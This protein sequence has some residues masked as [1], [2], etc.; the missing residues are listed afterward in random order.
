MAFIRNCVITAV[1]V[2][3]IAGNAK[4]Q[5]IYYPALSSSLLKETAADMAML[6]QKAIP[7]S[8]FTTASYN[9]MP[10][11]G[12]VFIY[13][14]TI[15][16]NQTCKAI[17]NGTDLLRFS[18]MQDN[19]LH[20]GV[21]QYLNQLGYRFYQPG[22]IWEK[23]PTLATAFKKTDTTYT[24]SYKYK[25]WFISGG[26]NRWIMDNTAA[27]SWDRYAGENGHNWAKFQRRNGMVGAANFRGHRG[28]IMTGNYITTLQN[29]PCY[30]ANYNGS[31]QVNNQSVP[32]IFNAAAI[33]LWATTIEQKYTQ[34]KNTISS[35]QTLYVNQYRNSDYSHIGLEVPDGS[36]WGNSKLN[37]ACGAANY[38]EEA[39]QQFMLA[40]ATAERILSKH[41]SVRFQVYAYSGH[42]DVPA[43]NITIN[44]NIDVQM[45]PTVY[46]LETSTGGLRNRWYNRHQ[47]VSEYHYLNLSGW[48]GETPAFNWS[49]LKQT[50]Q[51]AKEK[52]SQGL[53]WEASPAKFGSLPYLLAANN[54]LLRGT[55]VDNTLQEFCTNMFDAAS[56]TILQ[57]LQM[58]GSENASPDRYKVQLYLKLLNT[59]VQQ[60]Q[61]A[62]AVVKQRLREL[63]AYLHYMVL[64]YKL[65]SDDRSKTSNEVRDAAICMYLAKTNRLQLVNSYYILLIT[66]AKY[67]TS[68]SFYAQYNP[69]NGTAYSGGNIPLIS[70]AEIDTDFAQDL[71]QYNNM[72]NEFALLDAAEI[73]NNFATS[74]M[75][76]LPLINTTIGYT[77]GKDY[78]GKATFDIIAPAAGSFTIKYAPKFNTPGKG[79]I[80]FLVEATDKALVIVKD[81]TINVANGADV[82]TVNLPAAG[83]YQFSVTSK[84]QSSVDMSIT[85]NGN[86]FYKSGQFLGNKIES[87]KNDIKSLP[88][89][90][91]VP[92]GINR[93]Y[94]NITNNFA[95][96]RYATA[97]AIDRTFNFKDNN[98]NTLASKAGSAQD[99]TLFYIDIPSGGNNSFWQAANMGQYNLRFV[100]IGNTLW[101]AQRKA[102]TT[103]FKINVIKKGSECITEITPLAATGI[104]GWQVTDG[105]KV[106]TYNNQS[107]LQLPSTTTAT[108][109]IKLTDGNGCTFTKRLA[110][111]ANYLQLKKNCATEN[112]VSESAAPA[113]VMYPNPSTGIFNCMQNGVATNAADITVY[114]IQGKIV[115]RF[116]NTK[117]F[118]ISNLT[119]G[120]YLYQATINGTFHKGKIVKL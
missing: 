21:Y 40:N 94:Y 44:K 100:N 86:Y 101:F 13:D 65:N 59:A 55:S 104:I 97:D 30:V 90:F 3:C 11:A 1:L 33:D 22:D 51:V 72:A 43:A 28:D 84:Y 26:H 50:L 9:S 57:L 83:A 108:A 85:T 32:D 41:P 103:S 66:A 117:Q 58:W 23:I 115:G 75:V 67:G 35:N 53:V 45:I 39:D 91:Y 93:V 18:A 120:V 109:V 63:K 12:I 2:I 10:A 62:P 92:A 61:N 116:A 29:N 42:A 110:D 6:L 87:F 105:E 99:S 107:V 48:S 95:Y 47:A 73:K 14:N 34:Q 76:P 19:G 77:N 5:T 54:F 119:A 102:C 114:N 106:T 89:Y 17:G 78:Y 71:A 118:N 36:R 96:G 82:I 4:A 64:Q 16:D 15:T 111:D 69:I 56:G 60:T 31:R 98:G 70:A 112:T 38:P 37:D 113:A 81:V 8:R 88:G 49:D 25:T 80:N 79:Q 24:S 27:Y 7:G 20:F 68:S 46:Q 52:K 74:N